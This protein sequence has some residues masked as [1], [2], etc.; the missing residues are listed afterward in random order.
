MPKKN[1]R[2]F[3]MKLIPHILT[4]AVCQF[5]T[6]AAR[7]GGTTLQETS[8]SYSFE[9]D[10]EGWTEKATDLESGSKT[11]DWS[12]TRSQERA[13]DGN[14]S[15]KLYLDNINDQGKI[16][17]Q[18][19]FTVEPNQFYQ[20]KVSYALASKDW[21]DLNHFTIITGILQKDPQT[22]DDLT[23]SFQDKTGNSESADAGYKWLQKEYQI[24]LRSG[25]TGILYVVIGIWGTW[26]TSRTYYID[27]VLIT[28]TKKA[29]EEVPLI[30]S[31]TFNE[32]KKLIIKGLR[33][34]EATHVLINEQDSSEFIRTIT[35][36]SLILKG[37]ASKLGLSPGNNR[38]KVINATGTG[39]P[40]FIFSR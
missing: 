33:L 11:I 12:V 7:P 20:A 40:P 4:I 23:F 10:M 1:K 2:R 29:E 19:A 9:S 21:G 22:R 13:K 31:A 8:V 32:R 17:I 35:D 14:V 26:E 15:I 5:T 3:A 39:S 6:L 30:T 38:V 27:D 37:K 36:G 25:E 24:T 34:N 16:W 28:L 18:N